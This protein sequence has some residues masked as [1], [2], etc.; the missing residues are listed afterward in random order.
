[1]AVLDDTEPVTQSV[2][3]FAALPNAVLGKVPL[4]ATIQTGREGITE[5]ERPTA[6]L[7][8]FSV[9]IVTNMSPG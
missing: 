6:D 4:Q 7:E 8:G 9:S 1:M 2:E 5:D 3:N